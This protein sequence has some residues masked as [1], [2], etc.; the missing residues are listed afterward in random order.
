MAYVPRTSTTS[1]TA[2]QN[3]PWWYSTG[4]IYY[5]NNPL[6]NCTCYTYGRIGEIN[7]EFNTDLPLAN[8]GDWYDR[9]ASAGII[10][11]GFLPAVGGIVTY[12]DPQGQY[13][14]HCCVVEEIDSQ[15]RI[16]T[17]N[18]GYPDVYFWY[19]NWLSPE[20]GYLESWMMDRGYVYQGCIYTYDG[21]AETKRKHLPIWMLL[22]YG[23]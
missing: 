20:D 10:P 7:G 5:P 11:V 12:K 19:S 21:G 6:P 22:R 8:G 3:N 23:C 18:S 14:G 2:M 16:R 13:F 17:S 4:N 15:G 9:V 1:P